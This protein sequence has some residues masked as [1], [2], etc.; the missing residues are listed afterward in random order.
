MLSVAFTRPADT[1]LASSAGGAV[2]ALWNNTTVTPSPRLPT[3]PLVGD[4]GLR[5]EIDLSRARARDG[6]LTLD[7]PEGR[8]ATLTIDPKLQEATRSVLARSRAPEAAAVVMA[9]DGRLLALAGYRH[10]S[11]S[12]PDYK[13]PVTVWAPAASIFKIVTGAA[14][15]EAGVTP[16]AE[17]CYRGG[18]RSV[19]PSHLRD[20]KR[21]GSEC[22]NLRYGMAR[23]QNAVIAGLVH[24]HLDRSRLTEVA[25]RFGFG[26][27]PEFGLL[28]DKNRCD[29][30]ADDLELARVAAGF[31]KTE[32]S[33]LGGALVAATIAS[34]GLAVV[35]R[36]VSEIE[37]PGGRHPVLPPPTRRV[38]DERVAAQIA[39]MMIAACDSGTA[40][41]GFHDRRGRPFLGGAKVAGKTGSLS[42]TS[43]A[44]RSYSWFVGFVPADDPQIVISVLLAN[45]EKWHLKAHTAARMILEKAL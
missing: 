34:G 37:G 44:Y 16:D 35:P 28:A 32:L 1:A 19:E 9:I 12:K 43:P 25:R 6:A 38:L 4:V 36:I 2:L 42:V 24:R 7:L 11:P 3:G 29:L 14:L 13:L 8:R 10:A 15:L 41:K 21:P 26:A 18:L 27:N 5:G 40:Y 20:D 17:V 33:P 22:N 45:P 39:D 31:Y 30:P 23:S